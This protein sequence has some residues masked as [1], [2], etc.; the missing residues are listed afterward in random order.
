M[1]AVTVWILLAVGAFG[2]GIVAMRR[3][4]SLRQAH[5][6]NLSITAE[7]T[8][9]KDKLREYQRLIVEFPSG[10]FRDKLEKLN[11]VWAQMGETRVPREPG[12]DAFLF[13][14]LK[15]AESL[16]EALRLVLSL[17]KQ[18]DERLDAWVGELAGVF[19]DLEGEL[20]AVSRERLEAGLEVLRLLG[21]LGPRD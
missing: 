12:S 11:L 15:Y 1:S 8:Q 19:Q 7:E 21:P 5:R 18:P 2:L 9:R 6:Q 4:K 16:V 13:Y 14:Q 20:R 3:H 10:P 17:E